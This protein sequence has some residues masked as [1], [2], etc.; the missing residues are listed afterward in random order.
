MFHTK[1]VIQ[2]TAFRQSSPTAVLTTTADCLHIPKHPVGGFA[3]KQNRHQD[4]Q[5]CSFFVLYACENWSQI[6]GET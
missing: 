6:K 3:V 4:G 2:L 1:P 5:S